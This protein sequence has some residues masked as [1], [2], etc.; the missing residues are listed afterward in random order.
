MKKGIAIILSIIVGS[1]IGVFSACSNQ[2]TGNKPIEIINVSYDPTREFYE[3]FNKEFI[4]YWKENKN[5]DIV[6][7]QSHGGS[8][9]QGRS[10]IEG[11]EADVV[12]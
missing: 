9:K 5:Q 12:T 11:N 7:T 6:I 2:N 8:G 10:V 4:A 3:A 1:S